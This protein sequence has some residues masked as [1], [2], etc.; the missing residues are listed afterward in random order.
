MSDSLLGSRQADAQSNDY[1]GVWIGDCPEAE[2]LKRLDRLQREFRELNQRWDNRLVLERCSFAEEYSRGRL[3]LAVYLKRI[4]R[5]NGGEN[6][7]AY[8]TECQ[9]FE[10]V[11]V[12]HFFRVDSSNAL[13][14]ENWNQQPVF[15]EIVQ[16]PH[17]PKTNVASFVRLYLVRDERRDVWGGLL[18]T[19]VLNG[20]Y[21]FL[22]RFCHRESDFAI[23]SADNF[24]RHVVKGGSEIVDRVSDNEGGIFWRHA[25]DEAQD[26]VSGI[27]LSID[28]QTA[29]VSVKEGFENLLEVLDVVIG[30][31]NL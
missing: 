8:D 16:V 26:V 9:I 23:R 27:R 15:V 1:L 12:L 5:S 3:S 19:S 4:R 17:G 11:V 31:L 30:P 10:D 21:K 2:R 20:G 7:F 24:Y 28:Q 29:E 14:C 6:A 22:P 25:P 13:I 18:Y